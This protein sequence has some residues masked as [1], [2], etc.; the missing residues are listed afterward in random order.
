[1]KNKKTKSAGKP[2][3]E[4]K[5]KLNMEFNEALNRIARVKLPAKKKK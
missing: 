5:V 4:P 1:M 3:Y 2:K